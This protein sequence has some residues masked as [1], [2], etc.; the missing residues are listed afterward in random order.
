M[1]KFAE[2]IE[3]DNTLH[4]SE[5]YPEGFNEVE[6]KNRYQYK[7]FGFIP[8]CDIPLLKYF[9]C[10]TNKYFLEVNREYEAD[11]EKAVRKYIHLYF[12][13]QQNYKL[14]LE[15]LNTI[16]S[17]KQLEDEFPELLIFY[18]LPEENEKK[19]VSKEKIVKCKSLLK[20]NRKLFLDSLQEAVNG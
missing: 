6:R 16:N 10:K 5:N 2:Y 18:T 20:E 12:E 17:D 8:S 19:P 15:S 14:I 4:P 9:P 11:Y 13:A 3:F 7:A 1:E